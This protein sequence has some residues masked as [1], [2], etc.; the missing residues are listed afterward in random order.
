M[1]QRQEQ[2]AALPIRYDG[3]KLRVLLIT[4]RE[5]RRWIMPKGWPIDGKKSWEAA[6]I[7]ALEEAGVTGKVSHK[8]VGTYRYTKIMGDGSG[9]PVLVHLY[10]LY[11]TK[12]RRRWKERRERKRHW[13]SVKGAAEAVDEPDL[14]DLLSSLQKNPQKHPRIRKILP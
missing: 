8:P 12:L 7:E 3:G 4:S 6:E 11:V 10:P 9:L 2:Y 14:V 13:F 1:T 5:T